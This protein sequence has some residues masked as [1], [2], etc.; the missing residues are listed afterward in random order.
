MALT[1]ERFS[2]RGQGDFESLLKQARARFILGLTATPSR[3]D[4]RQPIIFMQC[5]PLRYTAPK[6]LE[7]VVPMMLS[8]GVV[9]PDE[10]G[11]QDMFRH[12]AADRQRTSAIV[13]EA[14]RKF[15]EGCKVLVLTELT[16]HC[17]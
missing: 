17:H 12:L 7:V 9:L 5:G 4:G 1:I 13:A 3:R 16:E 2:R 8:G 10:A 15:E 6:D 11:I 14:Q